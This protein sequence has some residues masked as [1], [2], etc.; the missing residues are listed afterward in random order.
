MACAQ[1]IWGAILALQDEPE[2][3]AKAFKNQGFLR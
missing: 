2:N 3:G 1:L